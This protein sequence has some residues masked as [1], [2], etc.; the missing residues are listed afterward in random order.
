METQ[1]L[2]DI[3]NNAQDAKTK[4]ATQWAV[5]VFTGWF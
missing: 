2:D 1:Q 3:V 4:E 5:S